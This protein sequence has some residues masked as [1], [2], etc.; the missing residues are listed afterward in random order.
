[1]TGPR[2]PELPEATRCDDGY[3][4]MALLPAGWK[5][6]PDWNGV[7]LGD[8]PFVVVAVYRLA[9]PGCY[10]SVGLWLEGGEVELTTHT[11][12]DDLR[13]RLNELAARYGHE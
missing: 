3:D 7:E 10:G 13:E 2:I 12:V 8:W 11:T 6:L 4:W 9:E 5:P 1:M